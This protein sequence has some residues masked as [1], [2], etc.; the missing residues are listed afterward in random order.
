MNPKHYAR[1]RSGSLFAAVVSL[2][3]AGGI[4]LASCAA[5]IPTP[6]PQPTTSAAAPTTAPVTVE[7]TRVITQE[8]V[9]TATPTP[10]TP[11]AAAGDPSTAEAI[12]G[13]LAPFSQNVAAPKGLAMQAGVGLA[14]ED[15][16]QAG[17]IGGKP[18]RAAIEDTAGDPAL[19]A[20]M[21]EQ[22]ITEHCASALVGGFSLEES[23]AIKQVS[24]RY[25]V[26]FLIVDATAD[27]LTSDS[28][29][30][31]FRIAPAATMLATLVAMPAWMAV[32]LVL[33]T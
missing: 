28:P 6:S 23:A 29:A 5:P 22:L 33:S 7:V 24:E 15:I 19:A 30:T 18:L 32:A 2:L 16:N 31:V 10:P 21:A 3:L 17:G 13:V 26:P 25:G 12:V 4:T 20:R 1:F 14:I 9:V 27:E 8:V 11:C